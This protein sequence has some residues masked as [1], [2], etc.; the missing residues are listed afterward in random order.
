M[1][2]S[3]IAAKLIER[4]AD[5]NARDKVRTLQ[6]PVILR[7]SKSFTAHRLFPAQYGATALF[8]AVSKNNVSLMKLLIARGADVN[9]AHLTAVCLTNASEWLARNHEISQ[10]HALAE[11]I[12]LHNRTSPRRVAGG[13]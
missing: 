1:G 4:S 6:V 9:A 2:R 7:F 5:V 8:Y 10:L 13:S 11:G 12:R 3:D